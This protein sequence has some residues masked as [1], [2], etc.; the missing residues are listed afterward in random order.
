MS[1]RHFL[2]QALKHTE[3]YDLIS[4]I[5]FYPFVTYPINRD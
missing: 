2:F 4:S 3:T 1:P 5:I